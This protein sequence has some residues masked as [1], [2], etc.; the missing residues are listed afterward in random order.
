MKFVLLYVTAPDREV[1]ARVG[2]ALVEER[3]AACANIVDGVR[4]IYRWEGRLQDEPETL[5]LAKTRAD[6]AEAAIARVKALHPYTCPCIVALPLAAGH[7]PF[8][9]WIAAETSGGG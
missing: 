1:A 5:L 4:S 6:L 9:E 2:R 7:A 3:L 8:L